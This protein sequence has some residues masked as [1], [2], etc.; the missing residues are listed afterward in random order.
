MG[1]TARSHRELCIVGFDTEYQAGTSS[2]EIL[3]YQT[4]GLLGE[5]SWSWIVTE[6]SHR[7]TL[8]HVIGETLA[9]GKQARAYKHFP[10]EVVLVGHFLRA[11]LPMT[12]DFDARKT[13]IHSVRDTFVTLG[14]PIDVTWTDKHGRKHPVKV[15]IRDTSLLAA[16]KSALEKIGLLHGV[17]KV[18]LPAGSKD[19]MKE[20]LARDPTKFR[21]Y[22]VAD[23]EITARHASFMADFSR[24]IIGERTVPITLSSLGVQACLRFWEQNGINR[25]EVLGTY[26]S[27]HQVYRGSVCFTVKTVNVIP[28]RLHWQQLVS[29]SYHGGRNE[30]F[31]YGATETGEWIDVDLKGAYS[32]ALSPIGTPDYAA[33]R[34]TQQVEDFGPTTLGFAHLR[35][36]FPE[37]TRFPCLPV[38]AGASL[39]YPLEGETHATAP[40]IFLARQMGARLEILLG[41]IVPTHAPNPFGGF[42]AEMTRLR[43]SHKQDRLMETM[44]KELIN[45]V[46][47]RVAQAVHPRTVFDS[48]TGTSVPLGPSQVTN[49]IFAAHT[50]GFVR[51]VMGEILSRIPSHRQIVSVTTDGFLTN[52]SWAEVQA[53]CQGPLAMAFAAARVGLT[54]SSEILEIKHRARQVLSIRTRGTATLDP[55]P[56]HELI[57]VR[58]GIQTPKHLSLEHQNAWV[59]TNFLIRTYDTR[60]RES[61]FRPLREIV[62]EGGDLTRQVREKRLRIDYDWKRQPDQV[63]TRDIWG[64]PRLAFTTGPWRTVDEFLQVRKDWA[65]FS[66]QARRCLKTEADWQAFQVYRAGAHLPGQG[67]RRTA[68]QSPLIIALRQVIRAFFRGEWGLAGMKRPAFIKFLKVGGYQVSHNDLKNAGKPSAKLAAHANTRDEEV[69]RL[70]DY[71]KTQFPEFREDMLLRS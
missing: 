65:Q 29:L 3:S 39:V 62:L 33:A 63:V 57:L 68:N 34:V 41:V 43:E 6:P 51:A 50:T 64:L 22:G 53:A 5:R 42:L 48:R 11:D 45:S 32:V 9:A 12:S 24:Q 69:R 20:F 31:V 55:E 30:C 70:C 35:F 56:G 2:N 26:A 47:G 8:A 46:Y 7:L 52:A 37:G 66:R 19:N 67:L 61:H 36:R 15:T 38:R 23:A 16:N 54:G 14:R 59:T 21:E 40:E 4:F 13:T 10:K 1:K 58:P 49:E 27:S 25:H 18:V 44:I 17:P 71:L 60:I 28:H